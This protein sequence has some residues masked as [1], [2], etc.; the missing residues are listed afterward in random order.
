M[1]FKTVFGN[2]RFAIL[3]IFLNA[4]HFAL[5]FSFSIDIFSICLV[6]TEFFILKKRLN[7]KQNKNNAQKIR[8][9]S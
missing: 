9:I 2:Q 8:T 5:F 1:F 3:I 4:C 6:E 7:F